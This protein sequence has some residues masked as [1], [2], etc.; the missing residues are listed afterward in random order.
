[1]SFSDLSADMDAAVQEHLCD[2]VEL[3]P[4]GGGDAVVVMAMIDQP[5]QAPGFG[6]GAPVLQATIRVLAADFVLTKGV[7]AMPGRYADGVFVADEIGWKLAAAPTR[8]DDGR[9][10]SASIE[11]YRPP[12]AP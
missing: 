8:E 4:V 10:Q 6:V 2:P 7:T 11:R 1:M 12:A 9:W 3:R 5:V